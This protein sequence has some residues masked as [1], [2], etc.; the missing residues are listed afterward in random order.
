MG[1]VQVAPDRWL[2]DRC[3][4]LSATTQRIEFGTGPALDVTTF[5]FMVWIY[6][7]GADPVNGGKLFC[8]GTS[9]ATGGRTL[10]FDGEARV[11]I[12][13]GTT[14]CKAGS[15]YSNFRAY[16]L[17]KWMC[18]IGTADTSVA[19]NNRVLIG[20]INTPPSE[21]STYSNA[22]S[23]GSGTITSNAAQTASVG[24][25]GANASPLANI[26]FVCAIPRV[27]QPTGETTALWRNPMAFLGEMALGCLLGDNGAPAGA[28]QMDVSFSHNN[29]T[30]T[31]AIVGNGSPAQAYMDSGRSDLRM[32]A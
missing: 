13:R 14:N 31:G 22:Q 26:A 27:L 16:D 11:N 23:A 1:L 15:A 4:N 30:I 10:A 3:L 24:F 20:D 19:G 7:T 5:T 12:F 17:N 25:S 18:V 6:K 21:P 2:P 28:T 32:S 8:K 29:G 9:N